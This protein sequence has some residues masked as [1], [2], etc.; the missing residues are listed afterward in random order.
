MKASPTEFIFRQRILLEFS[1]P[2]DTS[3]IIFVTLSELVETGE[4]KTKMT[5]RIQILSRHKLLISLLIGVGISEPEHNCLQIR[6]KLSAILVRGSQDTVL[7]GGL[8]SKDSPKPLRR[9]QLH[10]PTCPP[11][12]LRRQCTPLCS[13][14]VSH[15]Q[16]RQHEAQARGASPAGMLLQARHSV[17]VTLLR[18][19]THGL[20]AVPCCSAMRSAP[21]HLLA[22][23]KGSPLWERCFKLQACQ[24]I[25]FSCFSVFCSM[26]VINE[27]KGEPH[28]LSLPLPTHINLNANPHRKIK[29]N[30]T[31]CSRLHGKLKCTG[32]A[33]LSP[34]LFFFGSGKEKQC[35]KNIKIRIWML[36]TCLLLVSDVF[37]CLNFHSCC[38]CQ[39]VSEGKLKV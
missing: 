15:R 12:P 9:A 20:T 21:P 17:C 13:D 18:L 36:H 5:A 31:F 7:P 14:C 10:W 39:A 28:S 2:P 3:M 19:G 34:F 29:I 24:S 27:I 38:Q 4:S 23:I 25:Y 32:L 11:P 22:L 26:V 33:F 35:S 1:H 37:A 6:S 8:W 30:Y 16:Q